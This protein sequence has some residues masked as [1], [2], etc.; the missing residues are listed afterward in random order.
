RSH[1]RRLARG[2]QIESLENRTLLTVNLIGTPYNGL[3][4]DN[5]G[6]F[7]P[8]DTCGAAGPT[9]YI[10]TVNQSIGIYTGKTTAT[11]LVARTFTDF[12]FTQ[13]NLQRANV[14]AMG[15]VLSSLSDPIVVWDDQVN[16]F[17]VGDQD[18]DNT[19]HVDTFD[20]A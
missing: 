9:S 1:T 7:A 14:D 12:W 3:N 18:V 2:M 16:R 11:P 20:I 4:V 15:N 8:P 17:I 19:N 10:Q 6:G 5:G 13:G